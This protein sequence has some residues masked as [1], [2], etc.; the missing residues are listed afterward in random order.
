M[1]SFFAPN[2]K[3]FYVFHTS[4]CCCRCY[5]YCYCWCC[6]CCCYCKSSLERHINSIECI[7]P[8][9]KIAQPTIDHQHSHAYCAYNKRPTHTHKFTIMPFYKR[10]VGVGGDIV[11]RRQRTSLIQFNC[12]VF[13]R[14]LSTKRTNWLERILC[15]NRT[16][17]RR[18]S[19]ACIQPR[20]YQ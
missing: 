13:M 19:L 15:K 9:A 4:R 8:H 5:S 1:H 18:I 2:H 20:K 14:N 17:R 16:E 7:N 6:C 12:S 11:Q 10:A 3:S